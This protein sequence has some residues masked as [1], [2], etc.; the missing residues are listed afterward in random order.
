MYSTDE[1]IAAAMNLGV[2]MFL[3]D[4]FKNALEYN[5]TIFDMMA[6][7]SIT[8]SNINVGYENLLKS[9]STNITVEQYIEALKSQFA[10]ISGIT[11][12]F[13][14]TYEQVKLGKTEFTRVV[15]STNMQGVTMKQV[16]YLHK[17]DT[18]MCFLTVTIMDEYTVEQIEAMFN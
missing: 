2:D 7:D 16:Y 11:V 9:F 5:P 15:C 6:I 17:V 1:E 3:G 10:N 14:E 12:E 13:P 8:R 4:N 18:Y